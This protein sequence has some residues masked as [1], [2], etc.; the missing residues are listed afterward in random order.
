MDAGR[1]PRPHHPRRCRIL[2]YQPG[3]AA[4]TN[5]GD[6]PVNKPSG[7]IIYQGPSLLDGKPIVAIA[8]TASR[9][10]KTGSMVSIW[11]L[12]QDID[13]VTFIA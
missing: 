7:F 1:R 13:P 5:L 12:R 11:I 9:N 8:T 3:A 6:Y 10:V 2:R 4:P